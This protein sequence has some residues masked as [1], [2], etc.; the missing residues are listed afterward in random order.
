MFTVIQ[1]AILG[2]PP[3]LSKN[4]LGSPVSSAR[5]KI[6]DA[7]TDNFGYPD[8]IQRRTFP[9]GSGVCLNNAQHRT[10]EQNDDNG[11][12]FYSKASRGF[13]L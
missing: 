11:A 3:A 8:K 6:P 4:Q 12:N 10:C 9:S 5:T 7:V 1:Q 13:R 2:T